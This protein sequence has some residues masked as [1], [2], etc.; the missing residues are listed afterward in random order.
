MHIV[1]QRHRGAFRFEIRRRDPSRATVF[2]HVPKTSGTALRA[3]LEAALEPRWSLEALDASLFGGFQDF[4]S[5]APEIRRL[6]YLN[7]DALPRGATFVSGHLAASTAERGYGDAQLVTL[8]RE[9][10][11]RILSHWLFWR[12]QPEQHLAPWGG[13]A[14][15]V[16]KAARPLE[17]FLADPALACQLDNLHVRLLLWPHKLIPDDG[18]IAER[19]DQTLVG[20]ALARLGRFAFADL[21][22]NPRLRDSLESWCGRA[23]S[24]VRANE[25]LP[26]P[27][28][29]RSPLHRELTPR[30]LELLEACCRLDLMLWAALA[31]ARL[32]DLDIERL[33]ARTLSQAVA[34]HAWLM[35]V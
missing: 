2:I 32:P 28:Q 7:A 11:S 26:V 13:W 6:I 19:H 21:V 3:G 24:H 27:R 5:M 4:D 29:L 18:F 31:R 15:I 14:S 17:Q 16:R 8:I 1:R 20:E 33:R 34:R 12:A 10:Q 22:E 23:V 9:P 25:T 35:A 30:A